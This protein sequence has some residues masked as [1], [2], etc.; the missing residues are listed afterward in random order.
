MKNKFKK[1][2]AQGNRLPEEIGKGLNKEHL[3]K[4]MK[5]S[6]IKDDIISL[7]HWCL[8]GNC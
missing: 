3:K 6:T 2:D 8:I 4:V 1:A 5:E 7:K